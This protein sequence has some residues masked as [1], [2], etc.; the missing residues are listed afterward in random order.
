MRAFVGSFVLIGL[1]F[2]SPAWGQG[3]DSDGDDLS[4]FQ[5]IHKY[6][7]DPNKLSTAGDGVSDGDW[8]RR[9]EFTY[10]VR[11]VIRSSAPRR[12]AP[13][14][15]RWSPGRGRGWPVPRSPRSAG[16]SGADGFP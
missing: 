3:P 9:R 2:L 7:T 1:L 11:S 12:S 4:D 10:S 8:Q 13:G 15:P 14:N 16:G 6:C 5:E